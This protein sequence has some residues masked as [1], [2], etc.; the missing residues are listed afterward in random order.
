[1]P[2]KKEPDTLIKCNLEADLLSNLKL[3][4]EFADLAEGHYRIFDENG[5]R[6]SVD[7]FLAHARIVSEKLK[8]L[9]EV[10]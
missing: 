6:Y 9:R 5:F 8:K 7:Q 1:M 3:S 2:S 4:K 10:K